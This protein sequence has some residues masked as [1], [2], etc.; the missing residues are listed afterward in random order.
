MA[1]LEIIKF[2]TGSTLEPAL[3]LIREAVDVETDQDLHSFKI[4]KN[5]TI[6]N[7]LMII[8]TWKVDRPQPWGSPLAQGLVQ[9]FRRLGLVDHSIWTD[10]PPNRR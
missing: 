8:L 2:Q 7:E 1:S 9:E 3:E 10:L 6:A 4:L 5:N